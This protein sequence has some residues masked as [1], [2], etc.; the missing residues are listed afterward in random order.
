MKTLKV[1]WILLFGFLLVVPSLADDKKMS[2]EQQNMMEVWMKYATPGEGHKFLEKQAGE[3]DVVSKMWE[4]PGQEPTVTKGP[5]IGKMIMGGRYLEMS[6]SGTMMGQP[7]EG[8]S[9]Y[10][11][12]NHLKKYLSVWIDNFGTVIMVSTG[13]LDSSGKALTEWAEVDNIFTGD[14]EKAKTVITLVNDDMFLMEMYMQGPEGEFKSL[15]V[16]HIR[17]K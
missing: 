14:K 1:L 11:Y 6:Y 5:A 13:I 15:E 4:K 2:E 8:R 9:I 12:D 16:T 3:W 17:K 7:F 10:A